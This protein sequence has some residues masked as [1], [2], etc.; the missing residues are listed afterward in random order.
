MTSKSSSLRIFFL[1]FVI[2]GRI[3][4][5]RACYPTP[6]LFSVT[7]CECSKFSQMRIRLQLPYAVFCSSHSLLRSSSSSSSSSQPFM[8]ADGLHNSR[9]CTSILSHCHPLTATNFLDVFSPRL[10]LGLPLTHLPSLG[11]H[12]DVILAH[13]V[14]LILAT[15]PAHCLLMH[16]TLSVISF[17][18][19]LDLFILFRILSLF[20]MFNNR[21]MLCWAPASFVPSL[22]RSHHNKGSKSKREKTFKGWG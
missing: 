22:L 10:L 6:Y 1:L 18:L 9:Q 7:W 12:S 15:C 13:L 11:V 5:L 4:R 21:S 20:V 8:M 17:T 3:A 14:Q 19:V 2:I 16:R